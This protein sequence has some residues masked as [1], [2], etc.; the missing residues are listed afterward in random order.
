MAVLSNDPATPPDLREKS[1]RLAA[2]LLEYDPELRG[3]T[4]YARAREL[5]ESG[6]ALKQMEKIIDAQGPSTCRTDLGMLTAD[7][8]APADGVVSSIDCLRLNRLARTA[9]APLD[10][11]AGIKIF[12]KIGERVEKGEPLYR[13]FAFDQSEYD[14]AVAATKTD[15]G[16]LI[17]GQRSIPAG[18]TP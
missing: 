11:G 7:V 15:I 2:H 4:G 3:G 5:L 16:Y 9:G 8:G 18:A 12:K 13:I 1:L 17:D 14:L 6:I 10:K